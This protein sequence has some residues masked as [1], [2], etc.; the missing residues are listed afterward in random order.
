LALRRAADR[1]RPELRAWPAAREGGS[2][3]SV[4]FAYVFGMGTAPEIQDLLSLVTLLGPAAS[5]DSTL[6]SVINAKQVNDLKDL[7]IE[8]LR[9]ANLISRASGLSYNL[10][11]RLGWGSEI[12]FIRMRRDKAAREIREKVV[13]DLRQKAGE[14]LLHP[15]FRRLIDESLERLSDPV[16]DQIKA[17]QWDR[18][19]PTI[20]LVI[21]DTVA[22]AVKEIE[23]TPCLTAG[24]DD[25]TLTLTELAQQLE[26][27]DAT[28]GQAAQYMF[29]STPMCGCLELIARR[30]QRE[31]SRL[32]P[33]THRFLL[34]VSDGEPTD[35][36]PLLMLGQLKGA[37]VF[38]ASC[39][40]T[41]TDVTEP[42]RLYATPREEWP[43]QARLMFEA[44]SVL[45]DEGA[46]LEYLEG[47]GWVVENGARCFAQ[48][49]H[50]EIL[51][52]FLTLTLGQGQLMGR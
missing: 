43:R 21:T 52:E 36:D 28:F 39:F 27:A 40:V 14:R 37:G 8:K 18:V 12:H 44:A 41:D 30:F 33:G 11:Q 50:S 32:P 26:Q 10:M 6:K 49:N 5:L 35:G 51:E 19:E 15:F 29:G 34:L 25:V 9:A 7:Y 17:Q 24:R 45:S 31:E 4:V 1:A 22:R 23:S 3:E 38:I 20:E 13:R 16:E 47:R 46:Y 2:P 48:A 42:R